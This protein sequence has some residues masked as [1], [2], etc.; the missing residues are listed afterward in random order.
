MLLYPE[1]VKIFDKSVGLLFNFRQVLNNLRESRSPISR[2]VDYDQENDVQI[3]SMREAIMHNFHA[4]KSLKDNRFDKSDMDPFIDMFRPLKDDKKREELFARIVLALHM[5]RACYADRE[6]IKKVF[7]VVTQLTL[8]DP[9][10]ICAF[11]SLLSVADLKS[12]FESLLQNKL[13]HEIVTQVVFE[14]SKVNGI[15]KLS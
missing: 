2:C 4:N 11:T 8:I 15:F 14:I 12:I 7:R 1:V 13:V 6:G 3:E 10:N 5:S 9:E